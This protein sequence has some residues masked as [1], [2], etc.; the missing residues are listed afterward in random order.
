MGNYILLKKLAQMD[1]QK[2]KSFVLYADYA[3][4]LSV[5]DDKQKGQVFQQIFDYVNEH[6]ELCTDDKMVLMAWLQI[7]NNLDRDLEKWEEVRMKRSAAGKASAEAR[8]KQK[9]ETEE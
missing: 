8:Q 3:T 1:K 5:L 4:F 9:M 7:K 6:A 2:A